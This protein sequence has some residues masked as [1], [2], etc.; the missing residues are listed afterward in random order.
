MLIYA[1]RNTVNGKVYIGQTQRSLEDRWKRHV[2]V[3]RKGNFRHLPCAI[4]KYGADKF[5]SMVLFYAKD[6]P[7]LDA[8][9]RTYI[10]AFRSN[11]RER[12]YNQTLGG[13]GTVGYQHTVG[14]RRKISVAHQGHKYN[15]GRKRSAETIQKMSEAQRGSDLAKKHL[16]KMSEANRGHKYNLGRKHSAETRRKMSE[17]KRKY[18]PCPRY[19]THQFRND[20]CPCGF[21]R[22]GQS[23]FDFREAAA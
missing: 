13:E 3:A 21:A 15:L 18:P 19:G 5:Q 9:E 22:V 4:R 12:G 8:A 20:R 14:A 16:R 23:M 10:L 1:I 11:E 17:A 6:K 2:R 7:E